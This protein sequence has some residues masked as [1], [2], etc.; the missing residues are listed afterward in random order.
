MSL[1][2][3]YEKKLFFF[4]VLLGTPPVRKATLKVLPSVLCQSG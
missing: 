3:K 4:V 1:L 2:G